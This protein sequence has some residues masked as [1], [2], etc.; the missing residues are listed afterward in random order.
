[1]TAEADARSAQRDRE[2]TSLRGILSQME[3]HGAPDRDFEAVYRRI[4][5]LEGSASG[6]ADRCIRLDLRRLTTDELA[7]LTGLLADVCHRIEEAGE[8]DALAACERD[9]DAVCGE[10]GTRPEHLADVERTRRRLAS[11]R[12]S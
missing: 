2:L 12:P 11:W 6:D 10:L 1:M 3:Q 7:E 4:G 9:Y 8:A 5:E